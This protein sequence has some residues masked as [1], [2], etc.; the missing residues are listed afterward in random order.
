MTIRNEP[1]RRKDH[2]GFMY[3]LYGKNGGLWTI[4]C[5]QILIPNTK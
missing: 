2:E 4:V 3:E 1:Q 5:Y